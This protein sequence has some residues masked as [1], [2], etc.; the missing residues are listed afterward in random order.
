MTHEVV[1]SGSWHCLRH[2]VSP[3]PATVDRDAHFTY[4]ADKLVLADRRANEEE[5]IGH[6]DPS[7]R[8]LAGRPCQLVGR[9]MGWAHHRLEQTDS[10]WVAVG[11]EILAGTR[12][13]VLVEADQVDRLPGWQ[14]LGLGCAL[15]PVCV[16]SPPPSCVPSIPCGS[17]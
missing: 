4:A 8:Y 12:V 9:G 16:E 15:L 11:D 6:T 2:S 14:S 13:L 7:D 3:M 10:Q 17:L 1:N 5:G